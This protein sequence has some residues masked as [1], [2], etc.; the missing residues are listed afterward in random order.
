M[1]RGARTG[2]TGPILPFVRGQRGPKKS[3]LNDQRWPNCHQYCHL[4]QQK[5]PLSQQSCP[6]SP[7]KCHFSQQQCHFAISVQKD[8]FSVQKMPFQ[9]V[10]KSALLKTPLSTSVAPHIPTWPQC[11]PDVTFGKWSV[12]KTSWNIMRSNLSVYDNARNQAYALSL[13]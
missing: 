11:D 2:G 5:C 6:L 4:S 7:L 9:S 1:N 3:A 10:V 8:A 13:C 12:V